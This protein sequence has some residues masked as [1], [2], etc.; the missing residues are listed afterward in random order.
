[1]ERVAFVGIRTGLERAIMAYDEA[2]KGAKRG[3]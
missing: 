2:L 1:M 3:G